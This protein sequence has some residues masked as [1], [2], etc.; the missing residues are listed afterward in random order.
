ME[1]KEIV[2]GVVAEA[3][4]YCFLYYASYLLKV[5]GNLFLSSLILWI[6]ANIAIAFCPVLKKCHA[7]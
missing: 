1:T 5:G 6:L 2:Y 4:F 3:S 7:N